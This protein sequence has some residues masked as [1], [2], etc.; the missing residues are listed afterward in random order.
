MVLFWSESLTTTNPPVRVLK[1]KPPTTL[2]SDTNWPKGCQLKG[3]GEGCGR[4]ADGCF[5]IPYA[6]CMENIPTLG[7]RFMVNVGK[8]TIVPWSI[9]G[10][11]S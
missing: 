1:P 8:Y 4:V 2:P 3:G 5:L 7:L 6:P 11:E 9:W 10:W